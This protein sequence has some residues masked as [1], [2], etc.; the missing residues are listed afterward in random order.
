MEINEGQ[1]NAGLRHVYTAGASA[2]TVLATFALISP[3][4]SQ[5]LLNALHQ[6]GDGVKSVFGGLSKMWI[7]LGPVG[8]GLA[9]KGAVSSAG[10]KS[11]LASVLKAALTSDEAKKEVL[12]K[13]PE[14]PGVQAVVTDAATARQ[15]PN[16]KVVSAADAP[17][18]ISKS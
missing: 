11:Q 10:L 14:M 16:D 8:A 3:E 17:A 4:Q 9:A 7:I 12:Q 6:V 18:I 13:L 15:V 2:F 1:V 5:D